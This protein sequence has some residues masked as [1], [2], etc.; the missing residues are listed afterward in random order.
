MAKTVK[1]KTV[2]GAKDASANFNNVNTES[3]SN[4]SAP[5]NKVES[6]HI[7]IESVH[8]LGQ[9]DPNGNTPLM[10]AIQNRNTDA[11]TAILDTAKRGP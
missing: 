4:P 3:K 6:I 11:I 2:K 1:H 8:K 7:P 9:R 5:V 10:E